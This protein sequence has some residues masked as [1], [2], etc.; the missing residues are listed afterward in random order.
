MLVKCGGTSQLADPRVA[1]VGPQLHHRVEDRHRLGQQ[2]G[3]LAGVTRLGESVRSRRTAGNRPGY[4]R[5]ISPSRARPIRFTLMYSPLVA[6][7]AAHVQQ[8]HGGALGRVAGAMDLRCLPADPHGQAG[9]VADQGVD[10]ASRGCPC[11]PASRRTRR[12]WSA[13]S[14]T[15]PSPTTGPWCRPVREAC[16][17]AEDP[18]QQPTLEEAIGLGRELVALGGLLQSLPLGQLADVLLDLPGQLAELVDVARLGELGQCLQVDHADLGRLGR[19]LQL[20]EQ[21]VDRLQLL[22]D[23]QRLGASSAACGR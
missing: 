11:W 2:R 19:L 6:H 4:S 10:A 1:H 21:P 20:L 23:L 15:A 14:S 8:H 18:L 22:L 5:R 16:K 7:R 13:G 3:D 9:P 17:L 12:A